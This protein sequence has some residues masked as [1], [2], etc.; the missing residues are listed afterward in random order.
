MAYRLR[1]LSHCLAILSF[2]C[3]MACGGGCTVTRDTHETPSPQ[4]AVLNPPP[5]ETPLEELDVAPS[6]AP[7]LT[8]VPLSDLNGRYG[9]DEYDSDVTDA[10]DMIIERRP[11]VVLGV[12]DMVAGQKPKLNYRKMWAGFHR[13]VTDRLFDAGILFAPIAG[14]HDASGYPQFANEREIYVDEWMQHKPDLEYIDDTFYPLYYAYLVKGVFFLALDATVM[15]TMDEA[16]LTWV[17]Q[18]L[19][20]NPSPYPAIVY[21]HVPF[22]P[23]TTIK[24]VEHQHDK[25]LQALLVKYGVQL[26]ITGHQHAYYPAKLDGITYLH[27]GAIG[28]GTRPVQHNNG[29][30]PKVLPF[31]SIYAHHAPYIDAYVIPRKTPAHFNH[32]LLPTYIIYDDKVLPRADIALEDAE[33]AR[34]YMISPHMT[35]AQ[36]MTLIEALRANQ[37]DWS[38]IPK[39][40][41]DE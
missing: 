36:M 2:T 6:E 1:F 10:I 9:S 27:L 14:N 15:M 20:H 35:R 13:V 39:W 22:F 8:F 26:V 34:D 31:V 32:N 24:P 37:G 38:R 19:A 5:D 16:Q 33:F 17:E 7:L 3:L 18:Q 29:V 23:M 21:M 30:T 11:D 28:G 25:K 4:T 41:K 12:G 40:N